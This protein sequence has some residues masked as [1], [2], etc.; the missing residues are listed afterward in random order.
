MDLFVRL[1]YEKKFKSEFYQKKIHN[2]KQKNVQVRVFVYLPII[3]PY[4]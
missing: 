3:N 1:Y 2:L 4:F